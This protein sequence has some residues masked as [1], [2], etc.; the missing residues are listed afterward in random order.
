MRRTLLVVQSG[1]Q[2]QIDDASG[3]I[4]ATGIYDSETGS[5][6]EVAINTPG[7]GGGGG[8]QLETD[9]TDNTTQDLLNLVSGSGIQLTSDD[10]GD[11]TVNALSFA[12][13]NFTTAN[14]GNITA[15]GDTPFEIVPESD[16]M[17]IPI[18]VMLVGGGGSSYTSGIP[19]HFVF[20]YEGLDDA[21]IGNIALVSDVLGDGL[22]LFLQKNVTIPS[23]ISPSNYDGL[24][25]QLTTDDASNPTSGSALLRVT[26]NYFILNVAFPS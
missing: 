20:K 8:P 13:S 14:E 22:P 19:T 23:A 11:V 12:Q 21:G 2:L 6:S 18:S 26:I 9:G 25:L 16:G 15:I 17:I 10:A 5:T 24:A 4:Y 7:G 3:I 1:V